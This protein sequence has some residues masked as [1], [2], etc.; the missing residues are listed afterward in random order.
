MRS[1]VEGRTTQIWL[2]P[3]GFIKAAQAGNAAV[4][5]ETVRGVKKNVVTV[6][7]PMK[8]R[9]EGVLNDQNLVERIE[10]WFGQSRARRHEA[11]SDLFRSTRTSAA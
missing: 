5:A 4:R 10:T 9:L 1:A 3:H 8:V 7:T 6:T 11:R 2:T